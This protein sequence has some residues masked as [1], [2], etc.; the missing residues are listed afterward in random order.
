[1]GTDSFVIYVKTEDV[2]ED[3]ADNIKKYKRPLT[4]GED[5]NKLIFSRIN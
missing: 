3:I 2:Y 1:M 5:E 4:K